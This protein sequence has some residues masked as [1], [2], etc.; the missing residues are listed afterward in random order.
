[1]SE[2]RNQGLRARKRAA[3]VTSIRRVAVRLALEHGYDNVT[4]EMICEASE[5]SQRTFFNY[6]GSKDGVILGLTPPMP[7]EEAIAAFVNSTE[8]DVVVDLVR[9]IATA[10]ADHD[11]DPELMRSRRR[12]IQ[13]TPALMNRESARIGE[14]EDAL[15][16]LVVTRFTH[17]GRSV[18]TT[19]DLEEEARMVVALAAS[20]L[21]YTMRTWFSGRFSGSPFEL[22]DQ[23]I[24]LIHRITGNK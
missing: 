7:S 18:E 12:V 16:R 9:L 8:T 6:F 22:L 4:V 24:E 17:N 13:T 23:S 19:P 10:V 5:I 14:I 20:V 3:A 21:R 2:P 15:T 11:P 1:M